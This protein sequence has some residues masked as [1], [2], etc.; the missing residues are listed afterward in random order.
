MK[1]KYLYAL[2]MWPCK[3]LW[4]TLLS[5]SLLHCFHIFAKL[6]YF[7]NCKLSDTPSVLELKVFWDL[8][9][10]ANTRAGKLL[11]LGCRDAGWCTKRWMQPL[12]STC[13]SHQ[14][15]RKASTGRAV[16]QPAQAPMVLMWKNSRQPGPISHLQLIKAL[17]TTHTL[18]LSRFL[19]RSMFV[20]ASNSS[21][22]CWVQ[23]NSHAWALSSSSSHTLRL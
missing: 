18:L 19:N 23:L 1:R 21:T 4:K 15:I 12:L 3:F 16:P 9:S 2:L 20:D 11:C 7:I 6:H 5:V 10:V 14:L 13:T 17:L 22:R 8:P